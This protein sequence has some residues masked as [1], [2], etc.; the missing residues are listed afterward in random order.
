MKKLWSVLLLLAALNY[1][2]ALPNFDPF[3]D[4]TAS[5]GTSYTV[6]SGLVTTNAGQTNLAN[7]WIAIFVNNAANG[8]PN[9]VSGNLSYPDL[10][11]SSGNSVSF[12][13]LNGMS[14][15]LG[16]N[17]SAAPPIAFYSFILKVTDVSTLGTGN[18]NNYIAAFSDTV[19]SP[20]A[21]SLQRAGGRLLAKK[22]GTGYQ[23]GIGIGTTTTQY[24]YDSTVRNVGDSVVVVVSYDRLGGTTNVNL[25]VN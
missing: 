13:P 5:G 19:A 25:W 11:T 8:Q 16:L 2:T 18:V 6:G 12:G 24:V 14:A 4:A 3:T 23:L 1:A 9:I 15:R 17:L 20:Q 22:N 10:P 21:G 7:T